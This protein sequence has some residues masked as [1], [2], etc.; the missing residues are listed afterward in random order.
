MSNESNSNP[1]NPIT[2]GL[3]RDARALIRKF[4]GKVTSISTVERTLVPL[5]T[6]YAIDVLNASGYC[7]EVNDQSDEK[8][9]KLSP[10]LLK[11]IRNVSLEYQRQCSFASLAFLS[12][13]AQSAWSSLYPLVLEFY[14]YLYDH[15]EHLILDCK[16]EQFLSYTLDAD[17]RRVFHTAEFHSIA[18]VLAVCEEWR[19]ELENIKLSSDEN[20]EA[21]G[22]SSNYENNE[23]ISDKI[24]ADAKET[25]NIEQALK[26]L[27]RE[28]IV[29][30]GRR[31]LPPAR[32]GIKTFVESL[33]DALVSPSG[34]K[35]EAFQISREF[36]YDDQNSDNDSS[37]YSYVTD[38]SELGDASEFDSTKDTKARRRR[39]KKFDM[40]TMSRLTSR[41]ILAAGRTKPS[42]DAY[43]VVR[44]LFGGDDVIV[45]P[46]AMKKENVGIGYCSHEGI[47]VIV[48]L[49]SVVINVHSIYNIFPQDVI[50]YCDPLLKIHTTTSETI[51]LQEIRSSDY[52]TKCNHNESAIT[53]SI[54]ELD[55]EESEDLCTI[56]KERVTSCSGQRL[57]SLRP[58]SKRC[59][60]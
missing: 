4:L 42:G 27:R 26:D 56:L 51:F 44:D 37:S 30:N 35:M 24:E 5:L 11:A 47:E 58:V 15:Q 17:M 52:S 6:N 20:F 22:Q 53:K 43:F 60:V 10:G 49:S 45:V 7:G 12:P 34:T 16:L 1:T 55:L 57:L 41:L 21:R 25:C 13:P 14:R 36:V 31:F 28:T 48:R 39:R 59:G 18:H 40:S 38:T 50:D 19:W 33:G 8:I 23:K 32:G 9:V 54:G 46:S 29:I 3:E 2:K